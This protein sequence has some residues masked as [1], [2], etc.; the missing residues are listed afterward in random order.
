MDEN[1][2][3]DAPKKGNVPAELGNVM[4]SVAAAHRFRSVYLM[5]YR[6]LL[7]STSRRRATRRGDAAADDAA[8]WQD[9]CDGN[10]DQMG[11]SP[12]NS[13]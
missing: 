13:H 7:T 6:L 4:S 9:L 8:W 5:I 11:K 12:K 2:D 10:P 3:E 1:V